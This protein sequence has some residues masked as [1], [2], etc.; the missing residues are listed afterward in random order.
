MKR[1]F[2]FCTTALVLLM[3]VRSA[4]SQQATTAL[5]TSMAANSRQ[6]KQYTFKQRT[7]MYHKGDLK[8]YKLDEIHYNATGERISVP[9]GEQKADP[10]P[11]RHGPGSRIIA[12]K[13]ESKQ[14]EMKEYVER[15]MSL[16]SRYAAPEPG[17]LQ[18]AFATA[19]VTMAGG[20]N[21]VRVVMRNYIKA[22]DAITMTFDKAT[23]RAT[24]TEVTTNLDDGPVTIVLTYDQLRDGLTYPGKTTIAYD[25]EQ[26]EMRIYTY[27]YR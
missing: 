12:K 15:L 9:L 4:E 6:L 10:A 18:A 17:K 23:N 1:A 7:E 19:D 5:M 25:A 2:T 11:R 3:V 22:G 16:T 14:E 13:I 8:N 26:L 20:S 27:D 24:K 21:L